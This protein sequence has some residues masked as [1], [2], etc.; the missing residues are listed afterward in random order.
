MHARFIT[1]L[2]A[3]SLMGSLCGGGEPEPYQPDE[4]L[5]MVPAQPGPVA[6]FAVH[7]AN[8]VVPL[9]C[10][11][12]TAGTSKAGS[13]CLDLLP[14]SEAILDIGEGQRV[15]VSGRT[16]V[17]CMSGRTM[18][19]LDLEQRIDRWPV[20]S[21]S[22]GPVPW[23][24][25]DKAKPG[26]PMDPALLDGMQ[27]AAAALDLGL[28]PPPPD[29]IEIEPIYRLDLNG[30]GQLDHVVRALWPAPPDPKP[31]DEEAE[32]AEPVPAREPQQELLVALGG[33]QVMR[34]A[35]P[36]P[37]LVE[38][39]GSVDLDRDG[40]CEVVVAAEREDGSSVGIGRW[41]NGQLSLLTAYECG[42]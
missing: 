42:I 34:F 14:D 27:Q 21:W 12:P 29:Q 18:Q 15:G 4:D 16:S 26:E 13:P 1:V 9:A 28:E 35:L 11:D 33:Y 22:D 38:L 19:A 24:N 2:V 8:V 37:Q 31:T 25:F 32:D 7:S 17:Q 40:H 23:C 3:F 39:T 10:Y 6:L 30:D 41:E 20:V 5:E 36:L